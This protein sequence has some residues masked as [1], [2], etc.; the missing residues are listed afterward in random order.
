MICFTQLQKPFMTSINEY[1]FA[2]IANKFML[3]C[4]FAA[5]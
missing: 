3:F 4:N 1:F 2:K 5:K